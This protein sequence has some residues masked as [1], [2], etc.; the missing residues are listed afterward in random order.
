M[1]DYWERFVGLN[2]VGRCLL[3]TSKPIVV[4][5]FVFT[6]ADTFV[7]FLL[8]ILIPLIIQAF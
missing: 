4:L 8:I 7:I 2:H 3:V 5:R 1:V 6:P